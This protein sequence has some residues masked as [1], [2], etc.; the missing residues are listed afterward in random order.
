M[1]LHSVETSHNRDF[2]SPLPRELYPIIAKW[3]G[4]KEFYRLKVVSRG[5]YSKIRTIESIC[6]RQLAL[7]LAPFCSDLQFEK[8][9]SPFLRSKSVHELRIVSRSIQ[10][11]TKYFARIFIIFANV[12]AAKLS[13]SPFSK[14]KRA[15]H[16]IEEPLT[17][18]AFENVHSLDLSNLNLSVL[19]VEI[20][21]L[22]HL[23]FLDLS[24][25][26]L[27]FLPPAIGKLKNLFWFYCSQNRL[28]TF[29]PEIGKLSRVTILDITDNPLRFLPKT[30]GKMRRLIWL[31]LNRSQEALLPE[32]IWDLE[33]LI[34][35]LREEENR[36]FH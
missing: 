33:E 25:N 11:I 1:S 26:Q 20:S 32:E 13:L 22:V 7:S 24:G 5:V 8:F 9:L 35:D 23:H 10:E 16:W 2:L 31:I 17:Q 28:A 14:A 34:L 21:Y 36:H 6:F 18:R 4:F 12:I 29:P 27:Q 3:L 19:P 30:M 15:L